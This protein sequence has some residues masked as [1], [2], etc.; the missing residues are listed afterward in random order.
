MEISEL[1]MTPLHELVR[2]GHVAQKRARILIVVLLLLLVLL[3]FG[4][5]GRRNVFVVMVV[6]GWHQIRVLAIVVAVCLAA[7]KI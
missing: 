4:A 1:F 7:R 3:L 2:Y 5:F 6:A